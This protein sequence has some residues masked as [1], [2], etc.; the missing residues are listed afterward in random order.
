MRKRV[1]VG[2]REGKNTAGE[3]R[4]CDTAVATAAL[5]AAPFSETSSK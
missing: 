3:F 2:E 5:A 4:E 1:Q